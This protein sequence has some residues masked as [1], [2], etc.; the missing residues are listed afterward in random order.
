MPI[1]LKKK[2]ID[3]TIIGLGNI[4]EQYQNNRHNVG[5]I[6]I[7][8]L[9]NQKEIKFKKRKKYYIAELKIKNKNIILVKPSTNMN[10]S[11]D[12]IKAIYKKYN[13]K[14]MIVLFDEI[15]HDFGYMSIKTCPGNISQ[16]GIRSIKKK[17]INKNFYCLR[18]GIGCQQK[19][20]NLSKYVLSDF[21]MLE[22]E[23]L[24]II[25]N[26]AVECLFMLV[27]Q[28]VQAIMNSLNKKYL[29]D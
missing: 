19:I 22:K 26:K 6:I 14:K 4:G 13:I 7:E 28:D 20:H 15:D 27:H 10:N 5:F 29:L 21:S 17:L 16:N 12:A 11:G 24:S 8:E 9:C 3:L 25:V 2:N 18:V 1:I 23:Q